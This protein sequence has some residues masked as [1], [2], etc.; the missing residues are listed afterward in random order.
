KSV[1]CIAVLAS[2]LYA[3]ETVNA[4]PLAQCYEETQNIEVNAKQAVQT[5]LANKVE[6]S[7][8]SLDSAYGQAK[9]E[10]EGI[11]SVATVD[12]VKALEKSQAVFMEFRDAECERESAAM[13]GGTG[14]GDIL[15]SCK[16]QLNN[17]RVDQLS[18]Q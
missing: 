9:A 3:E 18:K 16:A 6:E 12:A 17:W 15:L 7:T 1:L 2:P 14:S 13:M 8:K 5:C 11:D 4:D 10:L